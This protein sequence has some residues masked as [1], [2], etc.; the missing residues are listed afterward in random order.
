[1]LWSSFWDEG[2]RLTQSRMSRVP[3]A[4]LARERERER[5]NR[6]EGVTLMH[7]Q[8]SWVRINCLLL[9]GTNRCTQSRPA[10]PK[11]HCAFVRV[12]PSVHKKKIL[13]RVQRR[14]RFRYY[15]F[16]YL[17]LYKKIPRFISFWRTNP[18]FDR[19]CRP[20]RRSNTSRYHDSRCRYI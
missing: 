19:C 14:K 1:M 4:K 9:A 7:D 3:L 13:R 15:L 20:L 5:E 16:F 18:I 6:R 12:L 8:A 10:L 17:I 2:G 11:S